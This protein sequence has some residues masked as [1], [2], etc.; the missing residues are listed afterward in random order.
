MRAFTRYIVHRTSYIARRKMTPDQRKR[1]DKLRVESFFVL[2]HSTGRSPAELYRFNVSG[3]KSARYTVSILSSGAVSC[4]CMD[5]RIAAKKAGVA[6]KHCCFVMTRVL[7]YPE[8]CGF[9]DTCR[10]SPG[11]DL[12]GLASKVAA[13]GASLD[14]NAFNADIART[15]ARDDA[16]EFSGYREPDQG[17]ECAVCY[18][19][20]VCC[21]EPSCARRPLVGCPTCRNAMHLDCATEW[22]SFKKTCPFCRSPAWERFGRRRSRR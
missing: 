1:F 3:S 14:V 18:T 2:D 9:Y 16:D 8:H 17:A 22:T 21:P 20:L 10:F 12:D 5:A 11:P 13:L 7:K 15:R 19:E 4:T 6:C